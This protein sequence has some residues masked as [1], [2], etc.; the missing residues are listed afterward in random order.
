MTNGDYE[1]L[2]DFLRR[3]S[4]DETLQAARQRFLTAVE[5]SRLD[6]DIKRALLEGDCCQVQRALAREY[7]IRMSFILYF[8]PVS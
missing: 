4:E 7:A 5:Q 3:I 2:G 1:D 6:P 8:S